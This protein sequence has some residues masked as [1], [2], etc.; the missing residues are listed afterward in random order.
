M[1][2]HH[3]RIRYIYMWLYID[4]N[5][6]TCDDISI[7][8]YM[9]IHVMVC[10]SRCIYVTCIYILIDMPS[11]VYTS[12]SIYHHMYIH[13]NLYTFTIPV[14]VYIS[15]STYHYMYIHRDQHIITCIWIGINI[16]PSFVYTVIW[17][18]CISWIDILLHVYTPE[19]I[20][21][22]MYKHRNQYVL[23]QIAV[24]WVIVLCYRCQ[25]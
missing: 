21:L 18:T 13:Q 5:V 3:Y 9:Y 6:S 14:Y 16:I 22:Y 4:A 15:G 24:G 19:S 7:P 23:I 1:H 8:M 10:W 17:Y 20:Y 25:L 12:G 11:H 2:V